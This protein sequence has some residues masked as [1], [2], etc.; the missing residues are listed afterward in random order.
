[1]A[2][3]IQ[4][5][6]RRSLSTRVVEKNYVGM[7]IQTVVFAVGSRTYRVVFSSDHSVAVSLSREGEIGAQPIWTTHDPNVTVEEIV[8]IIYAREFGQKYEGSGAARVSSAP[9][10]DAASSHVRGPSNSGDELRWDRL[11]NQVIRGD[12][13]GLARLGGGDAGKGLAEASSKARMMN[14]CGGSG[15]KSGSQRSVVSDIAQALATASFPKAEGIVAKAGGTMANDA[16]AD[17]SRTYKKQG[18]YS[19]TKDLAAHST[20]TRD[21]EALRLIQQSRSDAYD[22]FRTALAGPDSST[23][24]PYALAAVRNYR[25]V[26]QALGT[27]QG[28]A[29]VDS[30]L[31]KTV[32]DLEAFTRLRKV[33]PG[34]SVI[35]DRTSDQFFIDP[36]LNSPPQARYLLSLAVLYAWNFQQPEV[37][38]LLKQYEAA[39]RRVSRIED[40]ILDDNDLQQLASALA[41]RDRLSQDLATVATRLR[42]VPA[43]L[44]P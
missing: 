14:P 38:N 13:G 23:K 27:E 34:A 36:T 16:L 17:R 32:V 1:M 26:A 21:Q 25:P 7:K 24:D 33:S 44:S 39:D 6:G 5:T 42:R 11:M 22:I 18:V 40:A 9:A 15:S 29:L 12:L 19:L 41:E 4:Q 30:V 43:R 35:Y 10:A 31:A 3:F 8:N 20:A 37:K 28:K 2:A